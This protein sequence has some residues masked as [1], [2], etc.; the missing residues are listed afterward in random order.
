[1]SHVKL[2]LVLLMMP[3]HF[4]T[5]CPSLE[6]C[7]TSPA[8]P[9]R[10]VLRAF[11]VADAGLG[12]C[13]TLR[14][15]AAELQAAVD[16]D[17]ALEGRRDMYLNASASPALAAPDT[18]EPVATE[19]GVPEVR[20]SSRLQR[21]VLQSNMFY[22]FD[23]TGRKRA[24]S[25]TDAGRDAAP[26]KRP[27]PLPAD[28][29]A[30]PAPG[31][32]P[33]R[34]VG[35]RAFG[36]LAAGANTVRRNV[37]DIVKVQVTVVHRRTMA[38]QR[39]LL[40][41]PAPAPAPAAA[42]GSP[43]AIH[44]VDMDDEE[45]MRVTLRRISSRLR[46]MEDSKMAKEGPP[47]SLA[48]PARRPREKRPSAALPAAPE[49]AAKAKAKATA[50][51]TAPV[52]APATYPEDAKVLAATAE[53]V[54]RMEPSR[55]AA[56]EELREM[57]F[58]ASSSLGE[59][60]V[61]VL[62]RWSICGDRDG[63]LLWYLEGAKRPWNAESALELVRSTVEWA[64]TE[65]VRLLGIARG[66]TAEQR[67]L[68][69]SSWPNDF[70]GTDA[71]G[72]PMF[73]E[74]TGR[75]DAPRM[76]AGLSNDEML[77]LYVESMEVKRRYL[78]PRLS[79]EAGR[80]VDRLATVCDLRGLGMAQVGPKAMGFI[81]RMVATH[82]AGYAGAHAGGVYFVHA[83]WLFHKAWG[84]AKSMLSEDL[85]DSCS[86]L[87]APEELQD[88]LARHKVPIDLGG[89][90]DMDNVRPELQAL[91]DDLER[92]RTLLEEGKDPYEVMHGAAGGA[93]TSEAEGEVEVEEEE[94]EIG[95]EAGRPTG[96]PRE[97]REPARA[98]EPAQEAL[99]LAEEEEEEEEE[100]EG[101]GEEEEGAWQG[102]EVARALTKSLRKLSKKVV[103]KEKKA[104]L[105]KKLKEL[106]GPI[107]E[108]IPP[109]AI[110]RL[111]RPLRV[112]GTAAYFV[113]RTVVAFVARA[114]SRVIN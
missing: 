90:A 1:M 10:L 79:R 3:L 70:L 92:A 57:V 105:A 111:P 63:T 44:T 110:T 41:T 13:P 64:L 114:M 43:V 80:R 16:D 26:A 20:A 100:E 102:R 104:T 31:R 33:R 61:G 112:L 8:P 23:G 52:A 84:A 17:A 85:R 68:Y 28:R 66:I 76:A 51:A 53:E 81:R 99:R 87:G 11:A 73:L 98:K 58:G 49:A 29:A 34:P 108:I 22:S 67:A 46:E 65:R 74:R 72:Q 62:D 59:R 12:T 96:E 75:V 113:A 47:A 37:R 42:E 18:V 88:H 2:Y 30:P 27:R 60:E 48:P 91:L 56:L 45:A 24:R 103:G 25:P 6:V 94:E 4:P 50:K 19:G 71:K 109:R 77:A 7:G 39:L 5:G 15:G 78:F 9:G 93:Q 36:M 106:A 83:P 38:A 86:V 21:W 89:E 107:H 82:S 54:S 14:A 101:E 97:P 40:G 55:R 69:H 35:S 95:K 32:P